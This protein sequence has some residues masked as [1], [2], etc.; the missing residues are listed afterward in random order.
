MQDAI[1]K[2]H[3]T[4]NDASRVGYD[5]SQL[6]SNHSSQPQVE[7]SSAN[8]GSSESNKI[9]VST[10]SS[11]NT[12]NRSFTTVSS[13]WSHHDP[14]PTDIPEDIQEQMVL[15]SMLD[16]A[17]A[18]QQRE[19]DEKKRKQQEEYKKAQ[20]SQE[21]L[22]RINSSKC[23]S[24][25]THSCSSKRTY[26]DQELE[27]NTNVKINFLFDVPFDLIL[28]IC[29][30]L[31]PKDFV[32][33]S[34][35][36]KFLAKDANSMSS[37]KLFGQYWQ[38][39]V[40]KLID[41]KH[42]Q[43]ITFLT[44]LVSDAVT[45][46]DT[47]KKET[48][49]IGVYYEL[50]N[51][52]ACGRLSY[53]QST[54]PIDNRASLKRL[55]TRYDCVCLFQLL[56]NIDIIFYAENEQTDFANRFFGNKAPIH[57]ACRYGCQNIIKYLLSL[58][59]INIF[60]PRRGWYSIGN[61]QPLLIAAMNK[62]FKVC[63]MLLKHKSMTLDCINSRHHSTKQG[64]L[65]YA[66][67]NYAQCPKFINMLIDRGVDIMQPNEQGLTVFSY[68]AKHCQI[69]RM[70]FI[71]QC[72]KRQYSSE[73]AAKFVNQQSNDGKTAYHYLCQNSDKKTIETFI[74]TF[75]PD[76]TIQDNHGKRGSDF[77]DYSEKNREWLKA[78][79]ASYDN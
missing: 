30:Y 3:A 74:N 55:A 14:L 34:T 27:W 13:V 15:F 9:H 45:Q 42:L 50:S 62:H 39:C 56:R 63:E 59:N 23:K 77:I 46:H 29:F 79:E 65:F 73:A 36:C 1:A 37:K 33:F 68:S 51:L 43:N 24:T 32:S 40:K 48:N 6:Q 78:L 70:K 64:V 20:Q 38:L 75:N 7:S 72:A 44:E 18:Q 5:Q 12:N 19:E 53:H 16:E 17:K 25:P 28:E 10:R 35:T 57:V 22:L 76:I 31:K 41:K 58:P 11:S 2:Y 26:H 4:S 47:V 21:S 60:L 61:V 71:Y 52:D 54:N 8:S 49:W 67:Q 66:W 69:E